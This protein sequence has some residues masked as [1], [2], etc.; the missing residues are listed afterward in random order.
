MG[1]VRK[2]STGRS[3]RPRVWKALGWSDE[4]SATTLSWMLARFASSVTTLSGKSSSCTKVHK[5]LTSRSKSP[6]LSKRFMSEN[7]KQNIPASALQMK[8]E[9]TIF[10]KIV[11]KSVP[12]KII[13]ED[14]TCL[15]FHDIA[16]VFCVCFAVPI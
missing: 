2:D 5:T 11:S 10:A 14:E 15:A 6:R 13:Y 9:Y 12:A 1:C 8:P 3:V 4:A 7:N 16:Y